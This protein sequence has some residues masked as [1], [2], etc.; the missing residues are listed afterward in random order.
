MVNRVVGWVIFCIAVTSSTPA[1]A[2]PIAITAGN[3]TIGFGRGAFREHVFSL[4]GEGLAVDGSQPD[5]PAQS[6]FS[7]ACAQ[8][9]PCGEGAATNPSGSIFV[10]GIGS[11]TVDGVDYPLTQYFGGAPNRF[12]FTAG[13]VI[14]PGGMADVLALKTPFTFTGLLA[15]FR[16]NEGGWEHVRDVSLTGQGTATVNLQRMQNGF[17]VHSVSYEFAAA[18]PEPATLLLLGTGAAVILRRRAGPRQ[19]R[20]AA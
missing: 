16:F 12:T 6:G 7:P 2:D 8:F 20:G 18:T 3:I 14:I 1:L 17:S 5:G 10:T 9:S 15:I 11:A 13:D 4:Q 19:N